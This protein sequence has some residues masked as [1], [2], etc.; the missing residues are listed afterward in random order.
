MDQ[1]TFIL[2]AQFLFSVSL[3]LCWMKVN[4]STKFKFHSYI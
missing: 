1:S 2:T 4:F 3:Q